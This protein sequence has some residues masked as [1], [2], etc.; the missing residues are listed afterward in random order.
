MNWERVEGNWN[1]FQGK[2]LQQWSKLTSDDLNQVKGRRDALLGKLQE[3]YGLGREAAER[4][5]EEWM[6]RVGD[7]AGVGMK[8]A[9]NITEAYGHWF[10]RIMDVQRQSIELM[11]ER[12]RKAMELPVRLAKCGDPAEVAKTQADFVTTLV[13]DYFEGARKMLGVLSDAT[14]DLAQEQTA[15]VEQQV[16]KLKPR[17]TTH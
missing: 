16:R 17:S 2:M 11:S 6:R 4:Q 13:S 8:A 10:D 5:I 12:M 9:D 7:H 14:Q 1:E 15:A 3:R